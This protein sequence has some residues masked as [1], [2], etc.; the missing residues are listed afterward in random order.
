MTVGRKMGRIAAA[1]MVLAGFLGAASA[2]S[3]SL[4]AADGPPLQGEMR[5]FK[6]YPEP[7]AMP[8]ISFTSLQGE[9]AG[10]DKFHGK[11]VLLNLWA[12]WGAPWVQE[13]P[14]LDRLQ[15]QL[16]G[17]GLTVLALSSDRGGA[18]VVEPFLGKLGLEQLPIYLDPKN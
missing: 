12:T 3:W 16:G 2:S 1:G 14:S 9:A 6:L 17:E 5:N 11:V 8:D 18:N 13:M 4:L 10:L 15:A 7:K